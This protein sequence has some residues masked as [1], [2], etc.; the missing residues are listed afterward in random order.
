MRRFW[1][2]TRAQGTVEFAL[3]LIV[4]VAIILGLLVV[5]EMGIVS[6]RVQT[7]AR[8]VTWNSLCADDVDVAGVRDRLEP[9]HPGLVSEVKLTELPIAPES[10]V[11]VD[12]GSA[13]AALVM[14]NCLRRV[15]GTVAFEYRP[16]WKL[17]AEDLN[18]SEDSVWDVRRVHQVTTRSTI[19][20]MP[21]RDLPPRNPPPPSRG[22]GGGGRPRGNPDPP[23]PQPIP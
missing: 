22:G 19:P 1:R 2:E 14:R 12:D 4:Y 6:K 21:P 18:S 7:E 10:V 11:D 8:V 9:W 15:E 5:A 3:M 23:E 13:E 16:P 20:Y 17:V